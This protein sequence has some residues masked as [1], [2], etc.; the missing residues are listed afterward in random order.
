ML[1]DET[2]HGRLGI[3][4]ESK[5]ITS[6]EL[7]RRSGIHFTMISKFR[8]GKRQPNL[9]NLSKLLQALPRGTNTYWLIT[10]KLK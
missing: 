6:S 9:E 8:N 2:F 10:G 5:G 1:C 3:L 4:L 7:A